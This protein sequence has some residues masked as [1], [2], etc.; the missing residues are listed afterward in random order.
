[1]EKEMDETNSWRRRRNL[2]VPETRCAGG[3]AIASAR[4]GIFE[5]AL[6]WR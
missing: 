1:M 4:N 2:C 3:Q 5:T 6:I